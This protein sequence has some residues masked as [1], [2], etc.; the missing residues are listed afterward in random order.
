MART[1]G[2]RRFKPTVL[3]AKRANAMVA[4]LAGKPD[5][6]APHYADIIRQPRPKKKSINP[7]EHQIQA[8]VIQ[9]WARVHQQYGLPWFAL[10][11]IP[12]GGARD[13]ITGSL[14]RSEGVRPG[15]P[16]LMLPAVRFPFAGLFLELKTP[17]GRVSDSQKDW[18]E[19]LSGA[20]YKCAVCRTLDAAIATIT[21][22][23]G[24]RHPQEKQETAALI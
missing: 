11:A 22:Y 12:N 13:A 24:Y 16:D 8:A 17:V 5:V 23:L 21:D 20:G 9:W 18:L 7:S 4:A 19:Y 10:A 3:E 6:L 2:F 1:S 15:S 14:L